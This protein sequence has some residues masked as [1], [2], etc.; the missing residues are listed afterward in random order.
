MASS[1]Y[2]MGAVI[3]TSSEWLS[4]LFP[5]FQAK[6]F[7]FLEE[8][9]LPRMVTTKNAVYITNSEGTDSKSL[10]CQGREEKKLEAPGYLSGE[11]TSRLS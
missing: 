4:L 3:L 11:V 5:V 9:L 8:P 1:P 6:G 2:S 10:S 7:L